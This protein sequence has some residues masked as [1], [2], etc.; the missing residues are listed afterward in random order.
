MCAYF[1][2]DFTLYE[3]DRESVREIYRSWILF[4]NVSNY[5]NGNWSQG[6]GLFHGQHIEILISPPAFSKDAIAFQFIWQP[7]SPT[8]VSRNKWP[9]T[10]R[11]DYQHSEGEACILKGRARQAGWSHGEGSE[12]RLAGWLS[13]G[14]SHPGVLGWRTKNIT[15]FLMEKGTYVVA[16]NVPLILLQVQFPSTA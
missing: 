6:G 5:F 12:W 16:L 4:K 2:S 7:L 10:R 9:R 8:P 13:T 14:N 1:C 3:R 11:V 15:P